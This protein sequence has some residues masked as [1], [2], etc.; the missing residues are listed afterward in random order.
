MHRNLAVA[1]LA[2][3]AVL[4]ALSAL[5]AQV[6]VGGGALGTSPSFGA[7]TVADLT[8]PLLILRN[9]TSNRTAGGLDVGW[10]NGRQ[11]V[12]GAGNPSNT[13]TD[14]SITEYTDGAYQGVRQMWFKGG[15]VAIGS[16]SDDG[17]N[18]L[19]VTGAAKVTTDMTVYGQRS[20]TGQRYVC[21]DTNG[22]LVSSAAACS[23][24]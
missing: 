9:T 13:V 4:A 6:P 12:M 24:T 5:M 23:G 19:Q 20:T 21:I 8:A 1:A 15:R 10:N 11:W 18:A 7:V 16:T 22:K 14:F 3:L 17:V 2:G